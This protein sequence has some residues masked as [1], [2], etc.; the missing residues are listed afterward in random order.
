MIEG[1]EAREG[2]DE[3]EGEGERAASALGDAMGV[4]GAGDFTW[5][6]S[7]ALAGD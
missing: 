6:T 2:G 5:E 7:A 1:C 3:T 4:A